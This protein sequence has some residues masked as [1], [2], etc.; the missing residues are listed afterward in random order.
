MTGLERVEKEIERKDEDFDADLYFALKDLLDIAKDFE[1][2]RE[3]FKDKCNCNLDECPW[4]RIYT[5]LH[6][7]N[8]DSSSTE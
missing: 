6:I 8:K 1:L 4:C 3:Q 5:R 2:V 7:L